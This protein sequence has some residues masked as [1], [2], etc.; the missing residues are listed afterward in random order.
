MKFINIIRFFVMK[1]RWKKIN[2]NNSTWPGKLFDMRRIKIG[3]Y[4]YGEINAVTYPCE[5]SR[6]I[7][8]DFCSISSG[9]KFLLGGEHDFSSIS[10]FPFKERILNIGIDTKCK[11]PVIIDDD[12][13]VGENV[14]IL[15][16][17]HIGQG[18]VLAAGAV[19]VSDIPPYAIVGGVPAKVIKYRFS[20]EII[21]ELLKIDYSKLTE[22]KIK[23]HLTNFY[24]PLKDKKQLAWIEKKEGCIK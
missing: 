2:K 3:R 10:T 20:P 6:L 12:V 16:G 17:V 18:A 11:G 8:G 15:S 5:N 24:E 22:E 21:E 4:T 14:L 23:S 9:A 7:I 1:L 13:W 19:V